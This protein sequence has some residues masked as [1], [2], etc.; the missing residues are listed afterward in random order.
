MKT[1]LIVAA[2]LVTLSSRAALA[3]SEGGDTWS[4]LQPGPLADTQR[5][6]AVATTGNLS[7]LRRDNASVYGT[8]ADADSADRS[9]QLGS[10]S[11]WVNVGYGESVRFL[12]LDGDGTERSFAWRFDVAP[13]VSE[14]D[15][16]E[17]APTGFPAHNVQVFVAE[18]PRFN[19]D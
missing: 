11:H 9:V 8:P 14:V 6:P 3:A 7:V 16:S 15:L 5:F 10:Y 18:D 13:A 12:V 19:G 2:L 17:V 1:H 4:K